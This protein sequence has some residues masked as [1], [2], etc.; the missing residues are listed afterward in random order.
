VRV[1]RA[2]D[3][4]IK[5][6]SGISF[7]FPGIQFAIGVEQCPVE[8]NSSSQGGASGTNAVLWNLEFRTPD[9][10]NCKITRLFCSKPQ[11][12]REFVKATTGNSSKIV[13]KETNFLF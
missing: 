8:R 9:H 5:D 1:H 13:S 3:L 12:L 6:L 11:S 4:T 7:L 2:D 10:Q